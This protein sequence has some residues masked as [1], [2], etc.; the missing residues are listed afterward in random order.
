MSSATYIL[1]SSC[2]TCK[3]DSISASLNAFNDFFTVD[4]GKLWACADEKAP[5]KAALNSLSLKN[6]NYKILLQ[7]IARK[8]LHHLEAHYLCLKVI[9]CELSSLRK[10][11]TFRDVTI[12]FFA[13]WSLRNGRRNSIL[14]KRRYPDL[15]RA[16]DWS[17]RA[18]NLLQPV[19]RTTQIWVVTRHHYGISALFSQT[20]FRGETSDSVVKGR[21][22]S[23]ATSSLS[24]YWLTHVSFIFLEKKLNT[25]SFYTWLD[26]YVIGFSL[27]TDFSYSFKKT[28]MEEKHIS[29]LMLNN[30][31]TD[32]ISNDDSN[33]ARV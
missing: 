17:C 30:T 4:S 27:T 21:L 6:R 22:F 24:T 25:S 5:N 31:K 33:K 11:P 1:L 3:A 18:V 20:S 15:G 8:R 10:K 9:K 19:R 13:K 12:G 16:S 2:I 28:A 14:M 32:S 7:G 26:S 29:L 23:V